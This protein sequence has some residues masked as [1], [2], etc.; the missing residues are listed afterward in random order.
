MQVKLLGSLSFMATSG[1]SAMKIKT[2]IMLLLRESWPS[3]ANFFFCCGQA[4]YF[5]G[6]SLDLL[7]SV[8]LATFELFLVLHSFSRFC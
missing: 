2:I 6:I 1:F 3:F 7:P 4:S 8:L 5:D